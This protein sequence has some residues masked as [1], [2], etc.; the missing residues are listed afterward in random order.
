MVVNNTEGNTHTH[1]Q[2]PTTKN[3]MYKDNKMFSLL[4]KDLELFLRYPILILVY[5]L[6]W[7]LHMTGS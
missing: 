1:I 6:I 4:V 3:T 5:K 2:K 7:F